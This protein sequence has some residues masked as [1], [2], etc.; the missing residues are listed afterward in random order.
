MGTTSRVIAAIITIEAGETVSKNVAWAWKSYGGS[1][2]LSIASPAGLA[3]TV[4]I[5]VSTS[6]SNDTDAE[7]A[8]AVW[9]NWF[10]GS[11]A[12]QQTVP[13]AG[14]C[15]P[16]TELVLTRGIRLVAE[17]AVAADRVFT[18]LAQATY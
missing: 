14:N 15:M 5:E 9:F 17:E 6:E 11:P 7:N 10:N 1:A 13:L 4:N 2:G 18:I 3:E 8:A 16:Y 12:E